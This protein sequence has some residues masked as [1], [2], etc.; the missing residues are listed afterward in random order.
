MA[1]GEA[2]PGEGEGVTPEWAVLLMAYGGPDRLEDIEPFLLDIRGG[3]PTSAELVEEVRG[4]YAQIGGGSPLL[5]I[6]RA[7]ASALEARLNRSGRRFRV[8][9]GM[10][11]WHP[12]I[13]PV[14]Q[15]L[16][17]EGSRRVVALCLAPHYSRMSIGAYFRKAREA[18]EAAGGGFDVRWVD[19]WGDHPRFLDALA[20]NVRRGLEKFEAE[21]RSRVRVV[22]T[23]HSLPARLIAEGDPYDR[24]L[25]ATAAAVA[26][27][28][29]GI[30]WEFS[31]QS[32]G[33]GGVDWLGPQIE[34]RVVELA[35]AGYRHLLVAPV[36]FVADHVEILFDLDIEAR[37]AAAGAGARLERTDS[38]NDSPPFIEA[39][40]QIVL[41]AAS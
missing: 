16:A 36:G 30:E 21:D 3:R 13:G 20:A 22:F 5:E 34:E 19:K 28:V 11:H 24:Q 9:V 39:L 7:Q 23:A 31:Y 35:E 18:F 2:A 41:E 38:M 1:I 15:Q 26:R 12:Y 10:R 6:T 8:Y 37:R 32:A 17:D 4:R 27:R 14:V 33:A 40:A 25:R 29:P